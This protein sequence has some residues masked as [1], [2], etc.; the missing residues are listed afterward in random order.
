[1]ILVSL[2]D[3]LVTR[4]GENNLLSK[5][6]EKN[7]T[8]RDINRKRFIILD[9]DNLK[10]SDKKSVD[11]III[12]LKKNDDNKYRIILCELT[13]GNKNLDDAR[14]KF[15]NSGEIILDLMRQLDEEVFKIDCLVLGKIVKNGRVVSKRYLAKPIQFSGYGNK[16]S[17]INQQNCGFSIKKLYA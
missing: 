2:Y 16:N 9:G 17:V 4:C 13:S 14:E 6:S 3:E 15:K 8:L 12:D 7:C 11:C 5:C 1:M 10:K